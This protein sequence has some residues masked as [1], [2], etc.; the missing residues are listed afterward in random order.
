M[1]VLQDLVWLLV[2]YFKKFIKKGRIDR[3]TLLVVYC[4]IFKRL[5]CLFVLSKPRF[6]SRTAK[7]SKHVVILSAYGFY[8]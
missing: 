4:H 8:F 3:M 1:K 6:S 5:L 2:L 7:Q